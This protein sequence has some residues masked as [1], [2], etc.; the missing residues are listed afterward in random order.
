MDIEMKE[1]GPTQFE[2]EVE[3]KGEKKEKKREKE[4]VDEE[5]GHAG[6]GR[7]GYTKVFFFST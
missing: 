4:N 6:H 1:S 2:K 3:R 5:Q 7:A